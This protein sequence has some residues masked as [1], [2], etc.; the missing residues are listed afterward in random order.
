MNLHW[1][2]AE[3]L[4]N[5]QWNTV[6]NVYL[7]KKIVAFSSSFSVSAEAAT[8]VHLHQFWTSSHCINSV[9]YKT[10]LG[11]LLFQLL[12]PTCQNQCCVCAC[13]CICHHQGRK[14]L[15]DEAN[16]LV[17]LPGDVTL[18]AAV[19]MD[20]KREIA[21]WKR[22]DILQIWGFQ[23]P[24]LNYYGGSSPHQP[25]REMLMNGSISFSRVF[26]Y[27]IFPPDW[28]RKDKSRSV[29]FSLFLWQRQQMSLPGSVK[30]SLKGNNSL[31]ELHTLSAYWPRFIP[32]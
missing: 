4:F 18:T 31:R 27:W 26:Q 14:E 19:N 28:C 30:G 1:R 13:V 21:S 25:G 6:R 15:P 20:H 16:Q 12:Y 11:M 5:H 9:V 24:H 10:G 17:W 32:H 7:K 23:P 22:R 2:G 8:I 29:Y 3:V